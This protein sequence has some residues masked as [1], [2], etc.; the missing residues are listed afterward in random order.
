MALMCGQNSRRVSGSTPEVGS[1]RNSTGGLCIT[2]AGQRQPLLEPQRNLAGVAVAGRAPGR[3]CRPPG[4]WRARRLDARQAVHAGEKIEVLLHA[5]IAIERKLLGHVAQ[6]PPGRAAGAIQVV[7]GHAGMPG[8]GPQQ[9]AHHF[10]RGRFAGPV[11]PQQAV[12]FAPARCGTRCSSAAVKCA[13]LLG[14][15]DRLDHRA[16]RRRSSSSAV[17]PSG[18]SYFGP[19]AQQIDERVLES[20]RRGR[21]PAPRR[22]ERVRDRAAAHPRRSPIRT[23]LP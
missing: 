15:A 14:Q 21:P 9:P 6:P 7:A 23:L 8:R 20:R 10:E 19:A 22:S 3:T 2:A 4:P 13:E 1:S 12:D 17:W 18:D 16:L 11:R 5:Q